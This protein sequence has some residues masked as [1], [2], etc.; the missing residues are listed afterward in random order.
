MTEE[1]AKRPNVFDEDSPA[2][3]PET[4]AAFK[5]AAEVRSARI[6]ACS[7]YRK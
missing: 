4:R 5:R 2:L 3:T 1:A 6:R 7:H